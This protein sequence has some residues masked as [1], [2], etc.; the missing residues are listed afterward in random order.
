[1]LKL[2]RRAASKLGTSRC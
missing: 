1:M 2:K